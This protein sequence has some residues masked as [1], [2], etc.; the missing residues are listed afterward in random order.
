LRKYPDFEQLSAETFLEWAVCEFGDSLAIVTSFQAEG[1]AILDLAAKI[2]PRIRV[3]TVDTGRLPAET[4]HMTEVVRKRYGVSVEVCEPDP[5][6]VAAMVDRHGSN[7]FYQDVALR[8]LCCE[9]RKVRPL[10]RKLQTLGAW[11]SGIRRSHS[12]SRADVPKLDFTEGVWKLCPLADWTA[13]RVWEYIEA[14]EVP[15]HPLYYQGYTSIGCE[16]CTRA[17]RPGE[18]ERA[19]RW[20]WE[21]DADKE[22]GIHFSPDGRAERKLDVLLSQIVHA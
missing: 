2:E 4:R 7:L 16:P 10:Q 8:R 15:V 17:Q 1:M 19:G 12:E 21:R 14:N 3:V 6:E 18:D 11:V 22:C 9:V 5:A 13:R 20:W